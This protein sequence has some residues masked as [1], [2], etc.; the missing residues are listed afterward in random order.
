MHRCTTLL[1]INDATHICG[2]FISEHYPRFIP[3]PALAPLPTVLSPLLTGDYE[4]HVIEWR[5]PNDYETARKIGHGRYSEVFDSY[6]CTTQERCVIKVLKPI[7]KRKIRREVNILRNLCGGPNIIR[8]LDCVRDPVTKTPALVFEHVANTAWKTAV[9]KMTDNDIRFYIHEVARALAYAHSQGIMHRDVK[10]QNIMFDL[11]HRRVRLIDWGLAE[12]YHAGVEYNV[13]VASRYFK[14]P[15]L[16]VNLR[17]YDYSLDTWSLGCVLAGLIF[18][19]DNFFMGKDNVDQLVEIAKVLGTEGL[20]K[21]LR[22][23]SLELDPDFNG[24]LGDYPRKPWSKYVDAQNA[25]LATADAL[26]LLSKMLR[27]DHQQRLTAAEVMAHPYFDPIR[28][29]AAERARA[30]AADEA[31][32]GMPALVPAPK[33]ADDDSEATLAAAFARVAAS[34]AEDEEDGDNGQTAAEDN[35]GAEEA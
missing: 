28:E 19:R 7:K 13:R 35:N 4:N 12:F 10:P 24:L 27:W 30:V 32:R 25:H 16:L 15:E 1:P 8:L 23:Y 26:D 11:P 14:G 3:I 17:D 9:E 29:E 18:R 20:T 6:N 33:E 22:K 21:Y 2:S 5:S 31:A 34:K